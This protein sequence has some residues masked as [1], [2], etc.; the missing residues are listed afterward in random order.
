MYLSVF[1][2]PKNVYNKVSVNELGIGAICSVGCAPWRTVCIL[3]LLLY[4]VNYDPNPNPLK[5]VS[6]TT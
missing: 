6:R 2:L 5:C 3:Y 1:R 4:I